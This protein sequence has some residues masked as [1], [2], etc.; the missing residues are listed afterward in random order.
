MKVKQATFAAFMCVAALAACGPQPSATTEPEATLAMEA[1]APAVFIGTWAADAAGCQIPQEQ[2]GAP[3]VFAA[4][5]Y[6][7]HEAH[8]TFASVN[9]TAPNAWRIEGACSV[10]GDE[11]TATW[12]L[13]VD[14]DTMTMAPNTQRL[15]RCP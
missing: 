11:Q 9:Q 6:D 8:C 13:V 15:V 5:R 1:A 4:D 12:D 2:A 7:Q 10:E 3:H 14:G